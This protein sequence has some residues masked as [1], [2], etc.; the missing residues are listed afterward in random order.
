MDVRHRMDIAQ[1]ASG[2]LGH[3]WSDHRLSRE[4][5]LRLYKLSVCSS[6]THCCRGWALTIS[7]TRMINGF[8]SR[9]LHVII[10]ET[11][12]GAYY[13]EGSLFSDCKVE[14]LH[15][16]IETAITRSV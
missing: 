5:K 11:Y 4:T 15:E 2:S 6:L 10:G 3:L 12:R 13:P 14:Y 8:N 1:A 7:V 9:C 16:L